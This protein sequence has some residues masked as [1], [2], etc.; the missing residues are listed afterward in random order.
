LVAAKRDRHTEKD[1]K[2]LGGKGANL[3]EMCLLGISGARRFTVTTECCTAY[4]GNGLQAA[5]GA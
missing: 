4:Y 5:G 3:A 2:P 1:E